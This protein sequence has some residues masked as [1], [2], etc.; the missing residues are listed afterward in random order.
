VLTVLDGPRTLEDVAARRHRAGYALAEDSVGGD[1]EGFMS[2]AIAARVLGA[3]L[4]DLARS[5]DAAGFVPRPLGVNATLEATTRETRINTH[6]L[7]GK[8]P[9]RQPAKG[10]VLLVAHWDHFGTCAAPPAEDLICN[11][12]VDNASGLAVITEV[13]RALAR[14]KPLDRD[15]YLLATTAEELGLLGAEA[16][17]ENP[18]LPLDQIVAA[19][20]VDSDALA[21]AGRPLA[22]VGHGKTGLDADILRLAKSLKRTVEGN[23]V[24]DSFL[25]RQDG[26]ALLRHDIPTVMV[27]SSYSD[28]V[29]LEKFM[30]DTYH[31]PSDQAGPGLELGGAADDVGFHIA[32]VRWFADAKKFPA[33]AR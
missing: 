33:K 3:P 30:E 31:R 28:P 27:S 18:P 15:V 7:I 13:A 24:A 11:G 2:P 8:L 12:A 10:A 20:N 9:G 5:A 26:W 23:P 32:M 22:I 16:F 14:G 19:F 29:R 17:A 1:L 25:R 6:N 21:P 4:A